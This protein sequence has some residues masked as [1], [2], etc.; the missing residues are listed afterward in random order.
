M[1]CHNNKGSIGGHYTTPEIDLP[2]Q[3]VEI[4][5]NPPE[6]WGT[7]WMRTAAP[8]HPWDQSS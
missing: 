7:I 3:Y 4:D 8:V 5:K 2:I 6:V 1:E